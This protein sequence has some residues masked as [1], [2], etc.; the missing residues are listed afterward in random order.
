MWFPRL[1]MW[2]AALV[3]LVLLAFDAYWLV[4]GR[5]TAAVEGIGWAGGALLG[6]A[7][8]FL[9]IRISEQLDS[10]R[11]QRGP[12]GNIPPSPREVPEHLRV[13]AEPGANWP[14]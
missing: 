3:G 9:L 12:D 8:L 6:T 14:R 13:R 7:V 1:V 4:T 5:Y 11:W 10:W 2:L